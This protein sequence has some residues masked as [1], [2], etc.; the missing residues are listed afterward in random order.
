MI[1]RFHYK[2]VILCSFAQA[3]AFIDSVMMRCLDNHFH[4]VI[5]TGTQAGFLR[6]K[7]KVEN[8]SV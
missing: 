8:V 4:D 6:G 3:L 2:T 7:G 5:P 1:M